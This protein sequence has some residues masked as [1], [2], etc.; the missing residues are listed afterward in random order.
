M[1][2]EPALATGPV[3]LIRSLTTSFLGGGPDGGTTLGL[4]FSAAGSGVVLVWVLV[5]LALVV[6]SSW[7]VVTAAAVAPLEGASLTPGAVELP[8]PATAAASA[9]SGAR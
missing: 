4:V 6:A 3:P 1:T 7:R 9:I 2:V 8:Q 5:A